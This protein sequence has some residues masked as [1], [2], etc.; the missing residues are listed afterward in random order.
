MAMDR[1][2]S[3]WKVPRRP[4]LVQSATASSKRR[5]RC[6]TPFKRRQML[7]EIWNARKWNGYFGI[8]KVPVVELKRSK[9]TPCHLL[10][11]IDQVMLSWPGPMTPWLGCGGSGAEFADPFFE[12]PQCGKIG[13][14]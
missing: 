1:W 6:Y 12:L 2:F 11:T 14:F 8:Q 10:Q 13:S 3:A 4:V 7:V 9:K 5:T